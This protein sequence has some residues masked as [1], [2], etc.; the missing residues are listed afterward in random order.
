MLLH[1]RSHFSFLAAVS[2][3]EELA[4]A[5]AGAGHEF[6][7]LT[8][9]MGVYGAVRFETAC[10]QSGIKPI[11]GAEIEMRCHTDGSAGGE[12]H[13]LV[14]L[15]RNMSGYADL[16]A[17]LTEAHQAG[18]KNPFITP[19][20]LHRHITHLAVFTGSRE[21]LLSKSL[22]T[23]EHK[24]RQWLHTL[25]EI[26]GC[27]LFVEL[28][29]GSRPGDTSNMRHMYQLATRMDIP[30]VIGADVRYARA[31]D[32]AIYDL[33]TCI[34]NGITIFDSHPERPV[35][36]SQHIHTP[37]HYRRLFPFPG[38]VEQTLELGRSCSF[39]L[40]PGYI[41]P[42]DTVLNN[43]SDPH[44]LLKQLCLNALPLRYSN[45]CNAKPP[46]RSP[47]EQCMYELAVIAHL[48]L[49]GYFLLV[50]EVTLEARRRNIR[51]SGR[52]SAANSIVTYLLGI[53]TVDPLKYNLLFERFLHRGR[54][55]TPDIDID[56]DSERRPEII[57]WMEERFGTDK[58]AMTA[59]V[60]TY[61]TRMA[62]RDTAKALGW[63]MDTVN[64]LSRSVPGYTTHEVSH[65]RAELQSVAGASPM[66]D[67]LIRCA[68]K[69][70]GMPR[71]LGQHSG[72]MVLSDVSLTQRTPVQLSANGV[73]VVQFDKDDVE[74]L[75]LVKLDVLGLRMLAC[76]SE[77]VE[78]C[79]MA[80][81]EMPDLDAIGDDDPA[82]FAMICQGNT[83]AVFQIESQ[84]QMHLLAQHQP[85]CFDD[86]I[87]EVALFRPGPLQ[88]NMV[89]PYVRRRRGQEPVTFLHPSLEPVLKDTMGII[90]FQE[91]ILE[92]A[93]QVAGMSLDQAD[94]LRAL[95]SK[96]RDRKKMA[97][98]RQVF[99]AGAVRRGLPAVSA[100]D[101]YDALSHF[102]GYGFCRSHAAAF[103]RIVY[104][105]AW[106]KKYY[107][108]AYMAAFMQH[109]PGFY[110][111]MTLEE[112]TRRCGVPILLPD[113]N[114]SSIRYTVERLENG[115][116]AIRKP[117]TSVRSCSAVIARQI[118][119]ARLMG[120]FKSV[121][122]FV[123]RCPDADADVCSHLALGGAFDSIC[124]D[125]RTALW[126]AGIMR[127]R[128]PAP[129][130]EGQIT[131]LSL[132]AI[133]D[134]DV[135]VL[136][137]LTASER[138]A[139]DYQTHGAARIHPVTLY[140]R[141]LADLEV[142]PIKMA[143]PLAKVVAGSPVFT[144]GGIVILRQSPPTAHGVLFVTLEDETGFIQCIV[145]PRVRERFGR[146]L[147]HASL[148]I[149]GQLHSRANWRGL[150]V[151]EVYPLSAISGGYYGHL[152]MSGG[153]DTLA[154]NQDVTTMS[155]PIS[156]SMQ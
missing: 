58:T 148:I 42:P 104:Q 44:D 93:H 82:V 92:I 7:V 37:A 122:D 8:D 90:L 131:A 113:V 5:A 16:C 33:V 151:T 4:Q 85:S 34:R 139:Y 129:S 23:S 67:T 78:L 101:I 79:R 86:L 105:S 19:D 144:T 112:E 3:P 38:V 98:I 56:F 81:D 154:I 14:V 1:V 74:A 55:G 76:L 118:L 84:G 41:T 24:A 11:L 99:I 119:W 110:N 32:Y 125:S 51:F 9:R 31:E 60:I 135:P 61:R 75:G 142:R 143:W 73:S 68:D 117:L 133:S 66:L 134:A 63:P 46:R 25:R 153:T 150:V 128:K 70:E 97:A 2:S 22:Q 21:G 62:I 43:G 147:R 123:D 106:M 137:P 109:R 127:H 120:P 152:S 54:Q 96:N 140:R 107:P 103:A 89:N 130:P 88:G 65:Y 77:A 71:H 59:T 50:Y 126:H 10:R 6:C 18:R 87:T 52:G 45:P 136:P 53:T 12:A 102:V 29:Y 35:N 95:I 124:S 36:D 100:A 108:A 116:L 49:S 80:T 39:R 114:K 155:S 138:L 13:H 48:G 27:N 47:H 69:L 111:L 72:G 30:C 26:C 40:Q 28:Y 64:L 83:M 141:M 121:E 146:E 20:M 17:M 15:A 91:Q 132:S 156:Q 57:A 149:R 94:A 145:P 115:T